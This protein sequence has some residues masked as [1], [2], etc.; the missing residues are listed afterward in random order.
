MTRWTPLTMAKKCYKNAKCSLGKHSGQTSWRGNKC[1]RFDQ[2]EMSLGVKDGRQGF[3]PLQKWN[4]FKVCHRCWRSLGRGGGEMLLPY[5]CMDFVFLLLAKEKIISKK[6]ERRC[7]SGSILHRPK[8][9][10]HSWIVF[11][12]RDSSNN[13]TTN[14][15]SKLL[16]LPLLLLLLPESPSH[17]SKPIE[18][19]FMLKDKQK[20]WL[21]R[22]F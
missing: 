7:I 16:M 21:K 5:F 2:D 10:P 4:T 9:I 11:S 22:N 3:S 1:S 18:R 6:D 15:A 12:D 8:E 14:I 20:I 17:P 19:P 13:A